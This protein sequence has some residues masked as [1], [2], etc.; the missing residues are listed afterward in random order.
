MRASFSARLGLS[1][2]V[3]SAMGCT[4]API[5]PDVTLLPTLNSQTIT[6]ADKARDA[7]SVVGAARA[8]IA[9]ETR[10]AEIACYK[11]FY[12]NSCLSSISV[13]KPDCER[14]I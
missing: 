10:Q 1:V 9:Y 5:L 6:S 12:V 13:K 14:L 11:I 2:I 8:D 7:L 3:A 4:V